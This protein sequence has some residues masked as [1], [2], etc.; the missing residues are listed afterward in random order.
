MEPV[1]P[2]LLCCQGQ[3]RHLAQAVEEVAGKHAFDAAACLP[4]GLASSE[5]PFVVGAGLGVVADPL[6]SDDV[7][8]PV[9]LTVAA[10]VQPVGRYVAAQ[11]RPSPPRSLLL[12]ALDVGRFA[13][14]R[15]PT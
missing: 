13:A 12:R 5:K 11:L 14:H 6:E 2:T 7:Q 3:P 9:E 4:R 1:Q 8:R 15:W 10:A